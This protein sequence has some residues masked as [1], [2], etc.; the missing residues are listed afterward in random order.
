VALLRYG[1]RRAMRNQASPSLG[2]RQQN[3]LVLHPDMSQLLGRRQ[4]V[5][6]ALPASIVWRESGKSPEKV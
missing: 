4:S 6:I 3:W 2:A 1:D 5:G